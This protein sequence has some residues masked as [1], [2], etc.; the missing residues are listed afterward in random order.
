VSVGTI[1]LRI[2]AQTTDATWSGSLG[3]T[4]EGEFS[5]QRLT[6]TGR[7]QK[8]STRFVMAI[9]PANGW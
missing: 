8:G 7:S 1:Q 2:A 5:A 6:A 9:D 4:W 3:A